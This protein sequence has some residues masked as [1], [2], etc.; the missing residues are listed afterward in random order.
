MARSPPDLP[1]PKGSDG[2]AGSGDQERG[3]GGAA[4]R[5]GRDAEGVG[6]MPEEALRRP[7]RC[8]L[9]YAP[10]RSILAME[11][12]LSGQWIKA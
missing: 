10:G 1:A 11:Q 7:S 6:A 2:T 8:A 4:A 12:S 5:A 3:R 9:P